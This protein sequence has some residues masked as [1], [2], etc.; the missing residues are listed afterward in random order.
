MRPAWPQLMSLLIVLAMSGCVNPMP[1]G[2]SLLTPAQMTPDSV[3][4][5]LFFVRFP[6]GDSDVNEKLWQEIDE[7]HFSSEL[8]ERLA[9]N[10]FR[11]GTLSGQLP[12]KLAKLME[13]SDKPPEKQQTEGVMVASL[14][15][16]P[17]VVLRHLPLRTAQRSEVIASG[18]YDQLPVLV[19]QAGRI[20]GQ[21]YN[22]A[23]GIFAAK[24]LPQPDGQ[25]RLELVPELHHDQP[26]QR[27]VGDHGV[28]RLDASRPRQVYDDMTIKA[29]LA[30]GAMLILSSLPNRQGSLGHYFF[31]ENSARLEQKLLIVRLSQTQHDGLLQSSEPLKLEE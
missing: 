26:Q 17:R 5:D 27:W 28:L 25:V 10:G 31:T 13:L 9:R 14:E 20:S 21:T 3:V 22:Q 2:K 30:P 1:K 18:V 24:A 19:C 11:V 23:Q 12:D 15:A 4:L 7:Q 16:E 6:F 29:D 8:R